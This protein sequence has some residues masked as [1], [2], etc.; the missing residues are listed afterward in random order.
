MKKGEVYW[1]PLP[2]MIFGTFSSVSALF[3][4]V[5]IPETKNKKLPDTID[6]FLENLN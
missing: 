5:L 4:I 2:F 3:F 1:Y 6:E